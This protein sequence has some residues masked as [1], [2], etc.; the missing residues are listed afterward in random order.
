MVKRNWWV[1]GDDLGGF[2][3]LQLNR[4]ASK[5]TAAAILDAEQTG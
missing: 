4:S 5:M 3:E 1:C 2:L